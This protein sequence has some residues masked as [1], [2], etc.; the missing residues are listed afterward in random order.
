MTACQGSL[1]G[2]YSTSP[3]GSLCQERPPPQPR[4]GQPRITCFSSKMAEHQHKGRETPH[5]VVP[6]L[7]NS[8]IALVQWSTTTVC[9]VDTAI[10]CI[11]SKAYRMAGR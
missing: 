9:N 2:W 10:G 7:L 1:I 3:S 8:V 6:A 11:D 4:S 5:A